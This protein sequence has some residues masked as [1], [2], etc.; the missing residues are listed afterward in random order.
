V[1]KNVDK[2]V[3]Q[4][5]Y[6]WPRQIVLFMTKKKGSFHDSDYYGFLLESDLCL[7]YIG[8]IFSISKGKKKISDFVE[9]KRF[10]SVDALLKEYKVN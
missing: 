4:T 6:L 9:T 5:P 7:L 3:I 2:Y 8:D 1:H 10:E